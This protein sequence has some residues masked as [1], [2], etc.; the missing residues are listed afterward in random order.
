MNVEVIYQAA[1]EGM[2]PFRVDKWI[3]EYSEDFDF[4]G[5]QV[6]MTG[7][8]LGENQYVFGVVYLEPMEPAMLNEEE[9]VQ[10]LAKAFLDLFR[11]RTSIPP[12]P[13]IELGEN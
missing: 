1:N 7:R 2:W 12:E 3:L 9:L 13:N 8:Y 11:N 10:K 6:S 5:Y 4:F